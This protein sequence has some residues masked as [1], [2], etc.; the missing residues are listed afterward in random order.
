M[1]DG[2]KNNDDIHSVFAQRFKA[3]RLANKLSMSKTTNLLGLKSSGSIAAF[4][5][6]H[7]PSVETLIKI[8]NLFS[9]SLDYLLGC[10][11]ND[12]IKQFKEITSDKHK[13]EIAIYKKEIEFYKK[14]IKLISKA[15]DLC[16][17]KQDFEK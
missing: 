6:G 5:S 11:E 7:Y 15:V 9:V 2:L 4:E 17:V 3:L 8:S 1:C 12:R 14:Q 13:S 10:K 16:K